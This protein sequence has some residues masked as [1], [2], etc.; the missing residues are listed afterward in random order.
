[1]E[2]KHVI[3]IEALGTTKDPHPLQERLARLHG[4][5]CGFC[6]PGIIMSLYAVLRNAYDPE[7]KVYK[8][9][10]EMVELEGALDGNLCRCT[11][12]KPI[13]DAA[14]TFVTEDLKGVVSDSTGIPETAE[15]QLGGNWTANTAT[16]KLPSCGRPGG[17]CR[18]FPG[19]KESSCE[20]SSSDE[21][22]KSM[23]TDASTPPP[24]DAKGGKES[25]GFPQFEFKEYAPHTEIIFPL[26]LRKHVPKPLCFGDSRKI[27]FRPVTLEQLLKIKDAFPSAK[28]VGGSSEV[29]VE[30]RFK[31]CDYAVCVYVGDIP[32]LKGFAVSEE[33]GEVV[34]GGNTTLSVIEKDCLEWARKLGPRGLG[35]EA[36]RKQLR[37]FAGRQV[38]LLA[39]TLGGHGSR[40]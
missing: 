22:K 30:V 34:I 28:L 35:L 15:E 5:Q 19:T 1:V 21:D 27:W 18:D 4:S 8:L 2:G 33:K 9:T 31:N 10:R 6:T 20:S 32:E 14:K 37:Y 11:G 13:L 16:A 12:Y 26:A 40:I 7:T 39:F 25:Y 23:S 24:P 38:Y 17:C 36:M 29:Q 3:T